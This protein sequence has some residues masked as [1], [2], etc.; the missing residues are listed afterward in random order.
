VFFQLVTQIS[1]NITNQAELSSLTESASFWLKQMQNITLS[2]FDEYALSDLGN[3]RSM[4][5]RIEARRALTGWLY[6][7]K[8][9]KSFK[10]K[11]DIPEKKIEKE[12]V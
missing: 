6:G 8:D 1:D 11:Y 2:L 7:G 5:K 10:T 12:S 4:A 3:N 9:I